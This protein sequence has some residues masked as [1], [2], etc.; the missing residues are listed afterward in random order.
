M[1]GAGHGDQATASVRRRRFRCGFRQARSTR[2]R[3]AQTPIVNH[4]PYTVDDRV[5]LRG[6][7]PRQHD[8][9]A[10]PHA[11]A[12]ER[13]RE[14][15]Q[16]I[17]E[18]VG[19]DHVERVRRARASLGRDERRVDAVPRRVRAACRERVADRC[20]CPRRG[21]RRGGTAAIARIPEPHPK[22]STVSP[23]RSSAASQRRQSRVRRMRSRPE[24]ESRIEREIDRG[25]IDR[26]A[27]RRNDPESVGDL[28]RRELRLRRAHPV[29]ARRTSKRLV[30]RQR[31]AR[32]PPFRRAPRRGPSRRRTAPS[33]G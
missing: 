21:R 19:D 6:E 28:Q 2:R 1:T 33:A 18:N 27:P 26:L 15:L 30:R 8:A 23:A 20:R 32:A 29:G 25:G 3:S 13:R 7:D 22:S 4:R 10:G 14:H 5:G 12:R 9:A 24:R 17:R 16:R 31:C 11:M